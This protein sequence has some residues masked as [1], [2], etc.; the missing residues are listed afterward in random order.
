MKVNK[1]M[2]CK[3]CKFYTPPK[4]NFDKERGFG[5]CDNDKFIYEG[6]EMSEDAYP[7]NDKLAYWDIESYSAGG[8]SAGF[9]VG[10]NFGCI[11]FVKK[12]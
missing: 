6:F 2:K 9:N 10:E 8:Y 5:E 7:L 1:D 12:P 4:D 3:N 11:H